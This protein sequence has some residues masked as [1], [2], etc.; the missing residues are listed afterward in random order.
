MPKFV[1]SIFVTRIDD[2]AQIDPNYIR[3]RPDFD[4]F[5][6]SIVNAHPKRATTVFACGPKE[7]IKTCWDCVNV[8]NR[9]GNKLIYHHE[10]FDF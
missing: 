6:D 10:T 5:F 8:R 9:N 4:G 3:Q 1:P 2:T 7:M